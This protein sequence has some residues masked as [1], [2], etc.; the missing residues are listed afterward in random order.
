MVVRGKERK[1]SKRSNPLRNAKKK[2]RSRGEGGGT[3]KEQGE[4]KKETI[5]ELSAERFAQS[6]KHWHE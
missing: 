4:T 5:G 3:E 1:V 6:K 2:K